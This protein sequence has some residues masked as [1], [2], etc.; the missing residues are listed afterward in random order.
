MTDLDG[1]PW[2]VSFFQGPW[3]SLQQGGFPPE[4]TREEVDFI[5]K[6]LELGDSER[7]LDVPCGEGRHSIELASRGF[8]VSGTELNP[9]ALQTARANAEERG[10]TV[11]FRQGDMR[12]LSAEGEFDAAICYGGSFGYFDDEGN[13]EFVKA[14]AGALADSGRFIIDTPVAESLFPQYKER[15][16]Q[17]WD[18]EAQDMRVLQERSWDLRAGRIRGTWTFIGPDETSTSDVSIRIYTCRELCEL[19]REA[20]F[21]EF[22]TI[23]PMTHAPFKMGS[24]R[25]SLVASK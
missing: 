11:D 4:K 24:R 23:E 16:W 17:W 8:A 21:Q 5:V 15:D 10:V 1:G 22:R 3:G 6:A 14:V 20:G 2:W 13:L 25:L 7:V 18:E 9:N 12:S 19:L